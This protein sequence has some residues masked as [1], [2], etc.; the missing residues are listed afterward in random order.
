MGEKRGRVFENAYVPEEVEFL[1]R[2]IGI[3]AEN[4][5]HRW[6]L[7]LGRPVKFSPGQFLAEPASGNHG[8]GWKGACRWRRRAGSRTGNP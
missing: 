5:Y 2:K 8:P 4:Q 7:G 1:S 3:S 6:Y